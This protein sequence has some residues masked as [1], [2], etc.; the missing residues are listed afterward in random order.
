MGVGEEVV[1]G[2]V[3]CPYWN[4][5][6]SGECREEKNAFFKSASETSSQ[7]LT[8]FLFQEEKRPFRV[9]EGLGNLEDIGA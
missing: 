2:S 9:P 1:I 3:K 6:T 5:K 4:C 7:G 8:D